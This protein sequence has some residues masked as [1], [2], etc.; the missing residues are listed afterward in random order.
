VREQNETG[1]A[2]KI[3][4][5]PKQPLLN[6]VAL[7]WRFFPFPMLRLSKTINFSGTAKSV[8][9]P[10]CGAKTAKQAKSGPAPES[11]HAKDASS[12]QKWLYQSKYKWRTYGIFFS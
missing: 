5:A 3:Q 6:P 1:A 8:K 7:T 9:V 11:F 2:K 4:R 12:M 10:Q